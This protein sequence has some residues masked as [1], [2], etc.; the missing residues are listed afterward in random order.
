MK[1]I[2]YERLNTVTKG[3]LPTKNA[4]TF[5]SAFWNLF[6]VRRHVA[7]FR[8]RDMS[9]CSKARTCPRTP[10]RDSEILR[11]FVPV[12]DIPE[13][14]EVISALVLVFQIIRMFP[15]VH[16]KDDFA[17]DAGDSFAHERIVLVRRG[18]DF[19]FAT[20]RHQPRQPLPKRPMPAAS[21]FA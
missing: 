9:R 19:Q 12:H 16:A 20:I 17:F 7:A 11:D 21:N 10:N 5:I 4:L 13:R 3:F 8:Q 14:F 2:A 1:L 18:N 15:N 6:G